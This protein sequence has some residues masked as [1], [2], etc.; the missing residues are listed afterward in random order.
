MALD[1]ELYRRTIYLPV[2]HRQQNLR[3]ISVVDIHPG[4]A[5]RTLVLVHGYGG[6]A[7][8]WLYQ[9]RFFG[10]TM[11]VVAPDMRGHGL[12]DD[13]E[14]LACTM[15]S[16]VDDLEL[17]LDRL[18]VQRPFYLIAHS[19]GGA[20]AT[21]YTLRHPESVSG[22]VLVGVPT[23][24]ILLKIVQRLMV[25]P[26]PVFSWI[27]RQI[28]VALFAPQR[29]LK[30][31]LHSVLISW[32]GDERVQLL[33]V[34]TLVVLGQRDNVFQRE[35]YEDVPRSIPGAHKVVIPVSSHLVQLERPD[36]VNRAIRRFM[37]P[38]RLDG[39]GGA[40]SAPLSTQAARYA[41]MP[42]LQYYDSEVPE[43]LPLPGQ[44][45][46]GMLSN[47]AHEFPGRPAVIFFGQKIGYREL[48]HLSNRFAHAL[49][50][51]G[52]KSGDRIAILL[53]N[54]PQFVIAFYGTLKAGAVVVLGSPLSNEE[55]ITYQL[56]HSGA[57]VLLTLATYQAM[58][59]RVCAGSNVKQVI[60]TDVR[61]YLP[62][63]Q[64]V[65]LTNLVGESGNTSRQ[66]S[67]QPTGDASPD[68]EEG[69][70]PEPAGS[71][72]PVAPVAQ[73]AGEM[74]VQARPVTQGPA[75]ASLHSQTWKQ[76][77][78]QHLLRSQS[79][80]ALDSGTRSDDLALLQYTSGTTDTPKGVML[81]HSNLV[82][83]VAQVRHWMS[84]AKRGREVTLCALPLSHSYGVTDCMNL[85]IALAG[86]LVLL[87]TTR[88]SQLLHAIKTYHPTLFPGIPAF[89]LAIANYP[90]VRSYGVASIRVCVSGSAPLPVEVQEAFEKLTRGRLVEGYGLTEASPVTHSNPLKGE[91]RVGSIGIPL[92]GTNARIVD[93]RTG[94]TLPP[95][96]V[97]ELLIRGPQ[98]MQG[99]W[100][101]PGETRET[102]KNGWLRTGDLASMDEDG[103]FTIIDRKK[104]LIL[105]G[106]YNVYP[107]D[108][109]EVLYEHPKVLEV[110]VVSTRSAA[111]SNSG[112]N[113][114]FIKAVVVLK[115]GEKASADELLALCRER[116][117]A[118]KV[119]R[120]IEFRSEL[121]KN[122]VGKVLRR[123]LV[124]A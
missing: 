110:A 28:K 112:A 49:R 118:Y 41:E 2:G 67:T 96:E 89:Y 102:L 81:S 47:A 38:K 46:H 34:P 3:R 31:M 114:P 82:V 103:F 63:R 21:E 65:M 53:P 79:T 68:G 99:Y 83:N 19:F 87:P 50:G 40:R 27:A 73:D 71:K 30:R 20:I 91:R 12:S 77:D 100:N 29:T 17:V 24:F 25:I 43:S 42:W 97:G 124:D 105:A 76:H 23:R 62:V 119:P 14:E 33:R 122:F 6:S 7:T 69:M 120:Q 39:K 58:V 4:D 72:Q 95:N 66:S 123:L 22:L 44:L 74:Q 117:D 80:S 35:R 121:P 61:E 59:G 86:T 115:R 56:Q 37:E 106:S 9:L 113:S 98:V 60:F 111:E 10:Q 15:D 101:M 94:E 84:D 55:E 13:P 116:L 93:L 26:D 52:V 18:D 92:P 109:E 16:L 11:R 90:R 70:H 78:F 54:I 36:A 64:R 45:L 57:Q 5:T 51:L 75:R 48:D 85:S 88:T 107:R 32:R 8:Q 108:V 104:D 1:I